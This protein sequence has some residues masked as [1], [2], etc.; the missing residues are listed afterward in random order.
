MGGYVGY[1]GMVVVGMVCAEDIDPPPA[2][3]L[4]PPP[5]LHTHAAGLSS[6]KCA[7]GA[8]TRALRPSTR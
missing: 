5:L 6:A 4:R 8:R 2:C 3:L 1:R 7:S